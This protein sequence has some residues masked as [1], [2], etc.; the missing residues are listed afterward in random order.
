VPETADD[1]LRAMRGELVALKAQTNRVEDDLGRSRSEAAQERTALDTCLRRA[2]LAQAA[3][4][5][6]TAAIARDFAAKHRARQEILSAKV[7]V[8]ERELDE[9]RSSLSEL[10][11]RFRSAQAARE[12]L[13][14][15]AGRTDARERVRSTDALFDDLD[16]MAKRVHDL[17]ARA[18]AAEEL[19]ETLSGRSAGERPMTAPSAPDVDAQLDALKRELGNA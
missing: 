18:G 5:E 17:E 12:G 19:D 1:L 16:R 3:G 6:E 15:T 7:A 9:R 2:V 4:D 10:T 11:G 14:A 8:L 13:S